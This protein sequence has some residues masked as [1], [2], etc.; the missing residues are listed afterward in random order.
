MTYNDSTLKNQR[1][2]LKNNNKNKTNRQKTKN[3]NMEK[4]V[5]DSFGLLGEQTRNQSRGV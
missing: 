2:K 1:W 5:N 3:N 4:N